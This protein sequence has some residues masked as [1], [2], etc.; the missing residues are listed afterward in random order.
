MTKQVVNHNESAT[1][2]GKL[3]QALGV[4]F[5]S[6]I[7]GF[8]G[9]WIFIQT[10]LVQLD[11]LNPIN[12]TT[13]EKIV[14][15]EGEVMSSVASK[16]SPSV[17]S[18][19]TQSVTQS[20]YGRDSVSEGAGTG[21][22]ISK[23]GYI[24]TNKHV[25]GNASSL[26]VVTNDGKVYK[27]VQYVGSDPLN[28]VAFLKI[29]SND[30]FTPVVFADSSEV[31]VGE[32]VIAIGNALGEYQN[33]VTSGIISGIGR[34]V[35]AGEGQDTESL[36]NLLQTDAAI[37]PGNSGGPLI[38]LTGQV[39]GM[40]TAVAQDAQGIGFSIPSNAVRGLVKNLLAT[41]QVK[42][43]YLGVQYVAISPSV[44]DEYNLSVKQGAYI[45]SDQLSSAIVPGGPADKA[46]LKD[47]DII[48]KVNGTDVTTSNGLGV[49]LAQFA[50]G[51][52][53]TLTVISGNST[54]TVQV[55]LSEYT[56][57]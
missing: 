57:R 31:K 11:S 41:G 56:G 18:V 5:F 6:F 39:I 21:M 32:K 1:Q 3:V 7:A 52:K 26:S 45:V 29:K 22:I 34:P 40:N 38:N 14:S 53:V 9:A 42:R 33:S 4:I 30:T 44:A 46:G 37:N 15:Q 12:S 10:G 28:D 8:F 23:D 48:T 24:L 54:K 51:D 17:V 49:Q 50:P 19:T 55:T 47:K 27:D 20:Y 43:A 25:A 2:S 13:R 35:V 36:D 16:V